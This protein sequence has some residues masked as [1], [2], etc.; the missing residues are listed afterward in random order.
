VTENSFLQHLNKAFLEIPFNRMLGLRL[1]ELTQ[2]QIT[3]S[4]DMQ[5]ELIG[6]YVHGILHGGVISSVLD[7]AGGM[8]AMVSVV[9]KQPEKDPVELAKI[10]GK[11]GTI[12]LHVSY[13]QPGKGN[14][15]SA[16]ARVLR[17]GNKICFTQME[18]F[19]H[20]SV[21]IATAAGTYL[22]G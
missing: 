10:L 19:N 13:L 11:A 22:V 9:F 15:F 14:F 12:D 16:K 21:L 4:F 6:N 8:A 17:T 3:M 5:P 2:E 7:M 20:E 1:D 18:F